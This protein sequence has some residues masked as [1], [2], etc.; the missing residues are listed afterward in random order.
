MTIRRHSD[1]GNAILNAK[2]IDELTVEDVPKTNSL[3]ATSRRNVTTIASKIER[4][5]ILFMAGEDVLDR[6]GRDIPNL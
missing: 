6:T 2:S 4:V 3:I 1:C 5:N